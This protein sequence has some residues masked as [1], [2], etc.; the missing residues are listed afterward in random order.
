MEPVTDA[1]EAWRVLLD[2][3][4]HWWADNPVFKAA[5][6]NPTLRALFP[7]PTH[8]TLRFFRTPWTWPDTPAQNLPLIACGGP[9]YQVIAA[10]YERIIGQAE[11][12][13]EAADLV[14]A[15][16]P[17]SVTS[18]PTFNLPQSVRRGQAVSE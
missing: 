4:Q 15:N 9:P 16:L 12:A 3:K 18:S 8:G 1:D 10:G 11:S 17:P 5:Y 6:E 7:F 2:D 14:V 13:K